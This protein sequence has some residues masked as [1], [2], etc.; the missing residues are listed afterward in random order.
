MRS[1]KQGN[2][3]KVI[4]DISKQTEQRARIGKIFARWHLAIA[5]TSNKFSLGAP[6]PKRPKVGMSYGKK[7]AR[8]R[9]GAGELRRQ[10][11]PSPRGGGW[12]DKLGVWFPF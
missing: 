5:I 9:E 12:G 4:H 10:R 7:R 6:T 2:Y 1:A 11:V 8:R 3:L